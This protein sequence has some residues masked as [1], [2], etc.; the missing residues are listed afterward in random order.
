MEEALRKLLVHLS[1]VF[2]LFHSTAAQLNSSVEWLA[3]V[4]LRSSLG[5]RSADWPI[6]L[7]P[8]SNWNGIY[9]K[10]GRVAGINISGFR[11][12]HT[13]RENARFSVDSLANLTVLEVFNA[14]R[15]PLPG[16]IPSWFGFRLTSLRVLDLRFSSV[17]GPIPDSLGNLIELSA[18]HLSNNRLTGGMP[19]TLGQLMQLSVLDLAG[20]SLIGQIPSEF[21]LISSLSRLDLS[22]NYLSGQIPASLGNISGL[23]SMGLSDNSLTDSIPPELGNLSQLVELN[24]SKN[25]LSGSLPLELAKLRNLQSIEI[26]D[27]ELEGALPDLLFSGLEKLQVVN[28]SRNRLDGAIPSVLFSLLNLLVLDLSYNNFTGLV[29]STFSS[30]SS[31]HGALLNLSNNLLY[32]DFSLSSS[33]ANFSSIDLSGNYIQGMVPTSSKSNISV[34]KNCLQAVLNQKSLE[35]CRSFYAQR[36]LIFDDFGAPEPAQPPLTEDAPEKRKRWLYILLGLLVGIGFIVILALL[37]IVLLKK[38]SKNT[39]NRGVVADV[40]PVGQGDDLSVPKDSSVLSNLRDSFTYEQLL[41]ATGAFNEANLVKY[42]HSGDLFKGFLDSGSPIVVKKVNLSTEKEFFMMEAEL[43]SKYSH[44]RLVPFLG[45][46]S[47]N[48]N[49]KLLVYKYMPN[50]DLSGSLHRE[51]DMEDDSLKSLDWITRLKIAIGT[52]EGLSYLHHECNPPLVHRYK[53]ASLFFHLNGD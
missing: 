11:R 45:Y 3:L 5:L 43:F 37:M 17:T 30:N 12:T 40:E 44:I 41:R 8:C 20:N 22:S 50:G 33:I 1:L 29:Q 10:D 51:S 46:C 32:G 7:D 49:E 35:N 9:C 39:A 38:C 4:D 48:D 15:F 26:G 14:S 6:K 21:G 47:V 31:S 27:N 16:P 23:Q 25:S 52:A 28:F 19:S 13:G 36:G 24:L 53:K 2:L 34:E 42:G 18:L